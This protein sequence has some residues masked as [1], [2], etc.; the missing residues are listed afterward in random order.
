MINSN[1]NII[2]EFI[3]TPEDINELIQKDN[4]NNYLDKISYLLM[5]G[6]VFIPTNDV[7]AEN[8]Q[9]INS[10][11]KIEFVVNNELLLEDYQNNI[12]SLENYNFCFY[13]NKE[14][15]KEWIEKILSFKSLQESWDGFGA[16]PLE[17]KSAT[18][19]IN[20]LNIL[21]ESQDFINPTDIFPNP[22]G[23]VSLIWENSYDERLSLE[24]GNSSLSYYNLYNGSN[25][26]F[27]NNV[28]L[29]DTNIETIT[30]KI[31]SLF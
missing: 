4:N 13:K 29:I 19:A 9:K 3:Y 8:A 31:N 15:K 23:T 30:R 28:E 14:D 17:I 25:P 5:F 22:H 10:S 27:F 24:I 11:P 6:S 20:F 1:Y 16:M 12:L 18:N 7:K 21:S 2:Q 26:E